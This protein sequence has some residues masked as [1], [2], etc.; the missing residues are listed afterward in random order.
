MTSSTKF[1]GFFHVFRDIIRAMHSVTNLQEVID[2]MVTKPAGVLNAKGALIR[3][4]N[5]ETN[6]FEVR[7]AFGLGE[8]YLS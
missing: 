8:R 1:E 2:V 3:I 5:R 7:A 4:L 6:L